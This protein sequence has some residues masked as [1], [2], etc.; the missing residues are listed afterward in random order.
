M[1]YV[2]NYI[3]WQT[4]EAGAA[5]LSWMMQSQLPSVIWC[6]VFVLSLDLH[7]AFESLTFGSGRVFR[8]GVSLYIVARGVADLYP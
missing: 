4:C 5:A 2:R 3:S 7:T 6:P 8:W 1:F